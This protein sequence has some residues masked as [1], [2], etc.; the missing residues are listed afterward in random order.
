MC[1]NFILAESH[2]NVSHLH[3]AKPKTY[4]FSPKQY[5]GLNVAQIPG[6]RQLKNIL[7]NLKNFIN[8]S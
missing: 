4:P 8:C 7:F 5:S 3:A 1:H 6:N 2:K